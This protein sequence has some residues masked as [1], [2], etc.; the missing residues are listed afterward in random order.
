MAGKTLAERLPALLPSYDDST[1]FAE[2]LD[3]HQDEVDRL[4][5]DLETVKRSLQIA[6]ATGD[7]LDRIGADFGVLGR[8]RG[9]NDSPYRQYLQSLVQ[10]YRGR[11]TPPGVR[12]AIAAGVL[13]DETDISLIEDFTA[14]RYEVELYDWQ[15]HQT[16]TVR[17]LANIADPSVIQRRDP[18]HYH[19]DPVRASM[20]AS[21]AITGINNV[22]DAA[23]MYWVVS[24]TA[25][26]TTKV[27]LSGHQ[28]GN[29]NTLGDGM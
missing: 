23:T 20:T 4:D 9:R 11:G 7:E 2:W 14:N 13:V 12:K 15:A 5:A 22:V 21:T 1:D 26:Q 28:L 18:L 17:D 16:G 25:N 6:Y 24:D 29:G 3:A 19:A 8:R 10:A 27:G